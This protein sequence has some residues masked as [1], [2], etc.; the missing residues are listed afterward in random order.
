VTTVN[1]RGAFFT[2]QQ[3]ARH[4]VAQSNGGAIVLTSSSAGIVSDVGF[5][6]YSVA[7]IGIR[8]MARVAARELGKYGI[9]VN[10][11]APGPTRTP[12]MAGTDALPGFTDTMVGNTPLGRLGEVSDVA[13][14]V[15]ALFAMRWVTGQTLACDGGI[16]LAAGTDIPGF[17]LDTAGEWFDTKLDEPG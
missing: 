1:L 5:V 11:V 2:L 12:M 10:A 6:H 15:L 16:T 4:I 13:D 14:A 17:D 9:R 7:K 8:H 3:A